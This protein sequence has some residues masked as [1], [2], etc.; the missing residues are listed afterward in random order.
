MSAFL[1]VDKPFSV[2]RSLLKDQITDLLRESILIGKIPQGTRMIERDIA[3]MLGVSRVPVRDALLLLEAEGLIETTSIGRQVIILS[4]EDIIQLNMVRKSLEKLAVSLFIEHASKDHL[5][6]VEELLGKMT[7]A[8]QQRDVIAFVAT[9]IAAHRFIWHHTG[10]YHLERILNSLEGPISI[11]VS[12]HATKFDWKKTMSL[13]EDLVQCLIKRDQESALHSMDEHM[14]DSLE[15]SL[16][17][18]RE[19]EKNETQI[20]S[21]L[22]QIFAEDE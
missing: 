14:K 20:V 22:A 9:D 8:Y 1:K 11:V 7:K 5:R 10:N 18:I 17:N 6:E 19:Y 16:M 3:E 2:K 4:E 21:E 12:N 15:R 13:H